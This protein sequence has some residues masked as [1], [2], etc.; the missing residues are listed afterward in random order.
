MIIITIIRFLVGES[1]DVNDDDTSKIGR[2]RFVTTS[3]FIS[4]LC[5]IK[6]RSERVPY[7]GEWSRYYMIPRY[8]ILNEK[9]SHSNV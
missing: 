1:V 7:Q 8:M 2:K 5:L 9:M 3:E 4:I 6:K